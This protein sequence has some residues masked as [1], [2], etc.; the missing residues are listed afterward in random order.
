MRKFAVALALV[1]SQANADMAFKGGGVEIRLMQ[2]KCT[3]PKVLALLKEEW[4]PRFL[5][6]RLK[7]RGRDLQLCWTASRPGH[8]VIVDEDGDAAEVPA[9]VFKEVPAA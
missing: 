3:H 5:Q 4:A 7:H 9:G 1:A 2:E 8:I 6:G